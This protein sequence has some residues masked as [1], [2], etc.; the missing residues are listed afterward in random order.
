MK[1]HPPFL[2]LTG[3]LTAALI[4][5]SAQ[6]Q[7]KFLSA[8]EDLPLM[9]E[10]D[11]IKGSVMVFDSAQGRVVEAM[12]TGTVGEDAVLQFYS[13]TLPQLG[14]TEKSPGQFSRE[15][16]VLKLEFLKTEDGG[17]AITTLHFMLSPAQ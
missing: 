15:G 14:W 11:E 12:A 3:L 4:A 7:D 1:F 13:A 9:S 10:L 16:E 6:A 5:F 8:V 17:T 2:T